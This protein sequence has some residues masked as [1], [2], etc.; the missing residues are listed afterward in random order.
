MGWVKEIGWGLALTSRDPYNPY[1]MND[2]EMLLESCRQDLEVVQEL[3]KS[4]N[5]SLENAKENIKTYS[6]RVERAQEALR[7][8]DTINEDIGK[9]LSDE[10]AASTQARQDI[11]YLRGQRKGMEKMQQSLSNASAEGVAGLRIAYRKRFA[12]AILKVLKA[13]P[14]DDG[15]LSQ[16]EKILHTL[17]TMPSDSQLYGELQPTFRSVEDRI[18]ARRAGDLTV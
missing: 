2:A 6:E 15:L 18:K 9:T 13:T 11:D 12:E 16:M 10:R 14:T 7:T 1:V 8:I 17:Q 4:N 5:R 3:M